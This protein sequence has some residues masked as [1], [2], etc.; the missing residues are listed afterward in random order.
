M[1]TDSHCHLEAKDFTRPATAAELA[2]MNASHA[3]SAPHAPNAPSA[4]RAPNAPDPRAP[5][6]PSAPRASNARWGEARE[7]PPNEGGRES[8]PVIDE[9]DVVVARARQA[10]VQ[11]LVCIGS[12]ASLDEV[13]NA[14]AW[15][16]RDANIWAAIG[17]HPH[18]AKNLTPAITDRIAALASGNSRVCAVGE[19]G[20]DY[21]YNY[22]PH[23]VQRAA[24]DTFIG[25]AES[26][27]KPLTFHIRDAHDEAKEMLR[28]RKVGQTVGGIVHCFTGNAADARDYVE[29][30]LHVSFSGIVTFKTA[31]ELRAALR[32]VPLERLLIETDCPY[33]APLPM[34]GKRNEPAYLVH[35]AAFIANELGK[36]IAEI[37]AATT[38]NAERLLRLH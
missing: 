38:A 15:A 4:P 10:G 16:E 3:P 26:A 13:E 14:V 19:T 27:Q 18:D 22:S 29:M 5:N 23:D 24:L 6:A 17:I 9:R 2:A 36:D 28:A 25:I 32:N 30:G 21:H 37:A 7:A 12:G 35:T 34:R 1:F 8:P 31:G 20:L 33:L 11:K